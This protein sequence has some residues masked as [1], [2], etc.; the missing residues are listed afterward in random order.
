MIFAGH[1]LVQELLQKVHVRLTK[2]SIDASS[3]VT[4]PNGELNSTI[5]YKLVENQKLLYS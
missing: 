1:T 3:S 4:G 5:D 2:F